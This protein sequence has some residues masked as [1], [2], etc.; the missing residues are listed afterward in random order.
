MGR[1]KFTLKLEHLKLL[2]EANL[3]WQDCESGAP[4]ID[5]KRPYGNSYVAGDVAQILGWE[6]GED[7]LTEKQEDEAHKIHFETLTALQIIVQ[8]V[9]SM[10]IELGT[11]VQDWPNYP[12][13]HLEKRKT[14]DE[15]RI[16]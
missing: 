10:G 15:L 1:E 16:P 12:V 14:V 7:G 8:N 3:D 4:A 11:Y 9:C 6:V 13:W 2:K 5:C